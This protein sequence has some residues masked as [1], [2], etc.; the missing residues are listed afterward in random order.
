M[1]TDEA[2]DEATTILK[3]DVL[4][5]VTITK[6]Q[7]EALLDE[8]E[9][10]GL[11]GKPF[12]KLVGVNYQSFASWIQKRRR[13]RGDDVAMAAAKRGSPAILRPTR[14]L[15]LLEA[16]A[17]S[18]NTTIG[19]ALEVVLPGGGKLVLNNASQVALAAELLNA[20]R[21]SC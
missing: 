9:R 11:K 4:G 1:P 3:R 2:T 8:F 17:A 19:S 13:A 10:S 15:R 20:L 7:R 6:E 21:T 18:T 16:V 12:A 14:P 5:R